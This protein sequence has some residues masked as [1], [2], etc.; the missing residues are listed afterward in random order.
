MSSNVIERI[1]KIECTRLN[2]QDNNL[3]LTEKF[4]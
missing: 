2:A 3:K 1:R 4:V